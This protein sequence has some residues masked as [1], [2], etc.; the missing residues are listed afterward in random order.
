MVSLHPTPTLA[1]TPSIQFL[2][3][4]LAWRGAGA[5]V[6]AGSLV[7]P[8]KVI[9]SGELWG[10]RPAK[11]MRDMTEK[12]IAFLPVSASKYAELGQLHRNHLREVKTN[13]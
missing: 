9:P 2:H 10:G 7:T 13:T 5:M 3:G 1:D 12:E 4:L 6:A 8:G 11:Y